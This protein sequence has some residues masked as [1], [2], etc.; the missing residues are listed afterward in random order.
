MSNPFASPGTPG[1][2]IDYAALHKHLLLIEPT[3]VEKDIKTVYGDK[4]AV[5]ATVTV[6]DG[7]D[8]GTQH[9][10]TLIFPGLLIGQLRGK[11]GEKVLGRL[12]Q[13][14]GKPGQKPPWLLTEA[15]EDDIK[16]GTAYLT[17]QFASAD[18]PPF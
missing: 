3:S 18:E 17:G 6:L 8:A 9:T 10:D 7:P 5:R 11:I 1:S 12:A 16:I 14:N 4:E 2:G 15:S 13:G